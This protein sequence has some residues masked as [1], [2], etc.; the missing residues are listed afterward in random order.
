M[1]IATGHN[2]DDQAETVF[3]NLMR[4]DSAKLLS[5]VSPVGLLTTESNQTGVT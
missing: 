5:C 1:R 3:L 2:A 4:G